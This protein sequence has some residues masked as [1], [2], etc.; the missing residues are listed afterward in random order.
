MCRYCPPRALT[1]LEPADEPVTLC[2]FCTVAPA[3][4]QLATAAMAEHAAVVE[5]DALCDGCHADITEDLTRAPC[6]LCGRAETPDHLDHVDVLAGLGSITVCHVCILGHREAMDSIADAATAAAIDA[7]ESGFDLA[8]PL[9]TEAD[10]W[11]ANDCLDA[12][13]AA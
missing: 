8:G 9:P 10:W 1:C 3:G 12:G 2:A 11:P 13:D 5:G 7:M 6:G 4:A